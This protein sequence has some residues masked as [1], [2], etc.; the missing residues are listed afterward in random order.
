MLAAAGLVVAALVIVTVV[1]N[2]TPRLAPQAY[3]SV[4]LASQV[5]VGDII[6]FGEFDWRVLD[7][8]VNRAL[9]IT[10][11]VIDHRMFH[12]RN[13]ESVNW[14]QSGIRM[15]LNNQFFYSFHPSNQ[16]QI[17]ETYLRASVNPRFVIPTT[18][19]HYGRN[20]RDRVFLLGI[21]EVVH[22]FG[23][24][25]QFEEA[26]E[27]EALIRSISDEY[28]DA[29]I[30][31]CLE[32]SPSWWWLRTT[33]MGFRF[34]ALVNWNGAVSLD[35]RVVYWHEGNLILFTIPGSGGGIRPAMWIYLDE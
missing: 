30:A 7:L 29:R 21:E 19:P 22:Y 14:E 10:E 13:H 20:T 35:G 9:V 16:A 15:W 5:E 26:F 2:W 11:R 8:Q 27:D 4:P 3:T 25:G 1:M 6:R 18:S 31:Y 28:N 32:G 12:D 23:D 24:S 17:L 33:G 34:A